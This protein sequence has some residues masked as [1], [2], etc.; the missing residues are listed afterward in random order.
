MGILIGAAAI[1]AFLQGQRPK[2]MLLVSLYSFIKIEVN[3]ETSSFVLQLCVLFVRINKKYT[4][5][6]SICHGTSRKTTP[7]HFLRLSGYDGYGHAH[8]L[9]YVISD[10]LH[11]K[12]GK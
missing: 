2:T 9:Y 11:G 10:I 4:Y 12:F 6:N 8:C 3:F 5:K 1:W 7:S